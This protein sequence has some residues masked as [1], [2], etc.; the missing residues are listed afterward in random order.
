MGF[1]MTTRGTSDRGPHASACLSVY[2]A[3][4]VGALQTCRPTPTANQRDHI[5]G[6]RQI[7][8]KCMFVHEANAA[9]E[10]GEAENHVNWE[11][12][13]AGL[14]TPNCCLRSFGFT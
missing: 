2:I 11:A 7:L 3:L 8:R 1:A 9:Q 5:S 13:L 4:K 12:M 14:V 6:R 10:L